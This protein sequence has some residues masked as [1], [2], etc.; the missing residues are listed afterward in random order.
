MVLH[1]GY[2]TLL[3]CSYML[4]GLDYTQYDCT[5]LHLADITLLYYFYM[6]LHLA[7]IILTRYIWLRLLSYIIF[8]H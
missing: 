6:L 7:Y 5:V 2:I 4:L 3:C 8:I 1:L